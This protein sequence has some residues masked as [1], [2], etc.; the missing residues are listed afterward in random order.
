M[1][2][3]VSLE[4]LLPILEDGDAPLPVKELAGLSAIDRNAH[5]QFLDVWRRLSIQRRRTIIDRLA[6]VADDNIELDFSRVFLAGLLDDDV[7]VRAQSIKALWEYEGVDLTPLLLRLLADPEAIVRS[8]A[9]L[10]LGRVLLR[11]ELAD[12]VAPETEEIESALRATFDDTAELSEVRGRALEAL[13][14]RGHEWVRELIEDAYASG[15]R[16]MQISAVHAMGRSADPEWLPT[17]LEELHSDDG[18]MRFEA[19]MAAGSI[20]EE[21]AIA[22]LAELADD[23]DTEVQEAAIGALGEIGGPAARAALHQIASDSKDERVLEAVSDALSQA[24]FVDDPL[25]IQM[26]IARSVAEDEEDRDDDE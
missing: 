15:E 1:G 26:H 5:E 6:D 3:L 9:A 21:E 25:G 4:T 12:T 10:G 23:E 17:I 8:E 14:V 2:S 7:Q 13:G 16:R 18:E 22:D 11:A 20:A 19:A 24:D